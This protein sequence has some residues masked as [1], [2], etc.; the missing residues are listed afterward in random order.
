MSDAALEAE[1]L[2][3]AERAARAA[4]AELIERRGG[5]LEVRTKSSDTDPVSEADVAAEH[6]IRAVLAA[7]RPRD[8]ILG[9]EGGASAGESELRWI[10]DPLDGTVNYLYGLPAFVVSVACE[11]GDGSLVGVVF[12]PLRDLLYTATRSGQARCGERVLAGSTVSELSQAMIATGFSYDA[13]V[14]A[15]QG[16]LIAQMLPRIRD[17]RRVGAAALDLSWCAAG[18]YDAYFERSVKPWDIAAGTLLCERAGLAVRRLEPVPARNGDAAL[19]DGVLVA[20]PGLID[21]L[22]EWVS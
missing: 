8:A 2:A 18:R 20:P 5:P 13:D 15:V 6:A 16:R 3:V 12:D 1:L 9:E 7:A 4:G 10:V 11:D 14:R 17:I 21:E 19:P 22:Y